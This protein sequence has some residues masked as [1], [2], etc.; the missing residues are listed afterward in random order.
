V[1][2]YS[3]SILPGE[4]GYRDTTAPKLR[5]TIPPP[6]ASEQPDDGLMR[7]RGSGAGIINL[8]SSHSYDAS[9]QIK[10]ETKRVSDKVRIKNPDKPDQ[11][12]DV[13]RPREVE[14]APTKVG[15]RTGT[16]E[17]TVYAKEV[18]Q[19]HVEIIEEHI[20]ETNPDFPGY[21]DANVPG[22]PGGGGP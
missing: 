9:W 5:A 13:L 1:G 7:I 17:T 2:S 12:V 4:P 14:T 3:R 15:A 21:S 8:N 22:E 18:P 16:T 20:E 6:A 11:H 10:H 19:P